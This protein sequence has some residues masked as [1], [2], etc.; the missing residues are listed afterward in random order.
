MEAGGAFLLG[1]THAV[2]DD[3]FGQAPQPFS[4]VARS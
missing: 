4:T 2:G 3:Q 1:I